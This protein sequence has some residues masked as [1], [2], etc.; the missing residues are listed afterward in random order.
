MGKGG[1][2]LQRFLRTTLLELVWELCE[3]TDDDSEVVEM[4]AHMLRSG[5][6]RAT[7]EERQGI[8]EPNSVSSGCQRFGEDLSAVID[9]ELTRPHST[10]IEAHLASCG[11]C[12]EVV[13]PLMSV[14]KALRTTFRP[15]ARSGVPPRDRSG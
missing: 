11:R 1:E 13:T 10:E 4:V 9:G 2:G 8:G 7:K 12:Q 14:D 15:L 5:R 6:I 3:L